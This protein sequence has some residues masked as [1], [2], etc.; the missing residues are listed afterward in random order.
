MQPCL[1]V[2]VC[3][4]VCLCA[5]ACR[6]TSRLP[7]MHWPSNSLLRMHVHMRVRVCICFTSHYFFFGFGYN[8]R[9]VLTLQ[10]KYSGILRVM[11]GSSLA[12]FFYL[13]QHARTRR[14]SERVCACTYPC[15]F[16][17][18]CICAQTR[19]CMHASADVSA[20]TSAT[21][22]AAHTHAHSRRMRTHMDTNLHTH[23]LMRI[24]TPTH[25][26]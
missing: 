15:A 20:R 25:R 3:V 7:R 11:S 6:T 2:R 17:W 5:C 21:K 18:H 10:R 9:G 23:T 4:C 13:Q 16:V 19:W 14:V 24:H 8:Y 12:R 22:S 1:H 26:A